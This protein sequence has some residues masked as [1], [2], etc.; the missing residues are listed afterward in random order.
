MTDCR[1]SEGLGHGGPVDGQVPV[2]VD[3]QAHVEQVPTQRAEEQRRH[4]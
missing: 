4:L 2:E 1:S 3:H